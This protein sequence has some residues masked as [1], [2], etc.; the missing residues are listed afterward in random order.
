MRVKG[1]NSVMEALKAGL[2]NKVFVDPTSKNRRVLEILKNCERAGIPVVR[3]KVAE[4]I[5]ADVTPVKYV[6]FERILERCILNSTPIIFLD[7]IKDPTNTGAVI[8]TAEFFGCAGVVLT[9]RRSAQITETVARV[10]AGAVFHIPIAREDNL[11]NPIKK[12][13]KLSIPVIGAENVGEDLDSVSLKP[14]IAIV[15][16]EE[17]R[18]ISRPVKKQCDCIAKIRGY[19]KVG[20]LN[21]SNA[22]AIFIHESIKQKGD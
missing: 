13:K 5:E 2:I 11:V 6:Q 12:L 4:Q 22:A 14:P 9:K 17:D 15:I 3:K 19:G 16:G 10:S 7:S 21:L 1:I 8:R 20:S 18:G